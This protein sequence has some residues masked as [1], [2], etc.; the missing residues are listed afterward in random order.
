MTRRSATRRNS[1]ER[2]AIHPAQLDIIQDVYRAGAAELVE[3]RAILAG[4]NGG[5][6]AL[7]GS[8]CEPATHARWA[9]SIVRRAS[10]YGVQPEIV[11]AAG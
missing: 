7:G 9:E 8:M 1:P 10:L 11:A 4:D 3:A 2:T 6:F 5:V